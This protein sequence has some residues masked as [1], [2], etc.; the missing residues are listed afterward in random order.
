MNCINNHN[1]DARMLKRAR[2][3]PRCIGSR[4][5]PFHDINHRW[6][7]AVWNALVDEAP[8]SNQSLTLK[9]EERSIASDWSS[10]SEV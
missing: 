6:L 10:E 1:Q 9:E 8:L 2:G 7:H 5:Y 4:V 3:Y